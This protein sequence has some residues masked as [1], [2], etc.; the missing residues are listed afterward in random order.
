MWND[1]SQT[2]E[3]R[4]SGAGERSSGLGLDGK[5]LSLLGAVWGGLSK[6]AELANCASVAHN[7]TINGGLE[8]SR[9]K[10]LRFQDSDSAM[11]LGSAPLQWRWTG[12]SPI[13]FVVR[14]VRN[15]AEAGAGKVL[16]G[17]VRRPG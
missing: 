7:E 3:D 14:G 1:P 4:C 9:S 11:H 5:R 12:V 2:P 16:F 10:A 13:P 17:S 8:T 15:A 6:A